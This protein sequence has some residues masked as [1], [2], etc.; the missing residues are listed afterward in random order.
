MKRLLFFICLL[1]SFVMN[2]QKHDLPKNPKVGEVYGRFEI[3]GK[4]P[5]W[6]RV[7]EATPKRVTKTQKQLIDLG[8]TLKVT[9]NLDKATEAALLEFNKKEINIVCAGVITEKTVPILK[10]R[11][12]ELKREKKKTLKNY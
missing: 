3:E 5:I 9:G 4:D 11:L 12:K 6:L 8:Y 7:L 1:M 10:K 2:A